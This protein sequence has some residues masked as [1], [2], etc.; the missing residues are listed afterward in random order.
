MMVQLE[1]HCK[2]LLRLDWQTPMISMLT[3]NL[4][5]IRK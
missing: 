1:N 2:I 4:T 3:N 5:E